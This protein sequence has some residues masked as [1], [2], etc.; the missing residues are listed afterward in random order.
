MCVCVCV[1]TCF[2]P[3]DGESSDEG[4]EE[5]QPPPTAVSNDVE[6]ESSESELSEE[7]TDEEAPDNKEELQLR[8]QSL[9]K[10]GQ[11]EVYVN[12]SYI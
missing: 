11:R 7:E 8:C 3:Q 5:G 9:K 6:E 4:E 2:L 10:V 12:C 1:Y